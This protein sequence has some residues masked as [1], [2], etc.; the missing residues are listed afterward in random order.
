M[1]S[2]RP[3]RWRWAPSHLALRHGGGET[4]RAPDGEE[5]AG[6]STQPTTLTAVAPTIERARALAAKARPMGSASW[7]PQRANRQQP[8]SPPIR[9]RQVAEPLGQAQA[10][11]LTPGLVAQ[12]A[13]QKHRQGVQGEEATLLNLALNSR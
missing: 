6:Q 13:P 4:G 8:T 3:A 1:P 7:K 12:A 2:R 9:P 11:A 5:A 10:Q